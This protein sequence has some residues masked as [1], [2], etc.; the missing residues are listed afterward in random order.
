MDMVSL[1]VPRFTSKPKMNANIKFMLQSHTRAE[2]ESSFEFFRADV[3]SLVLQPS[4]WDVYFRQRGKYLRLAKR[5]QEGA[6]PGQAVRKAGDIRVDNERYHPRDPGDIP[7]DAV[8][9]GQVD[10]D[11]DDV[12]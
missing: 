5:A 2:I 4:C 3:P 8:I 11:D 7:S 6:R 9:L 1:S 10:E 12:S